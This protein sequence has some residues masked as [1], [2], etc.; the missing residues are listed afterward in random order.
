MQYFHP[1]SCN[2]SSLLYLQADF[3][4]RF[5]S[6]HIVSWIVKCHRTINEW[7]YQRNGIHN[8]ATTIPAAVT[9]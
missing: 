6:H 5:Q 2:R 4:M 1:I 7:K 3:V 8:T 9:K